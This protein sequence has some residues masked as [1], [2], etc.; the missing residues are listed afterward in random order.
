MYVSFVVIVGPSYLSV[1]DLELGDDDDDGSITVTNS[2]VNLVD[3]TTRSAL[4]PAEELAAK[5]EHVTA[6]LIE[7]AESLS[8]PLTEEVSVI[9]PH[10][11]DSTADLPFHDEPP[12]DTADAT[13]NPSCVDEM[14]ATGTDLKTGETQAEVDFP[15]QDDLWEDVE[16]WIPNYEVP[17]I[18][19]TPPSDVDPEEYPLRFDSED[20]QESEDLIGLDFEDGP[21]PAFE[22][23]ESV[24]EYADNYPEQ[25]AGGVIVELP[26]SPVNAR[27]SPFRSPITKS[28][29]LWSDDEGEDPG[30]LPRFG[31]VAHIEVFDH[32]DSPA[33]EIHE[34]TETEAQDFPIGEERSDTIVVISKD[35]TA[36]GTTQQL[37]QEPR[38]SPEVSVRE[39]AEP[40]PTELAPSTSVSLRPQSPSRTSRTH[41]IHNQASSD[42]R[43]RGEGSGQCRRSLE[44][45][46]PQYFHCCKLSKSDG[47]PK[48][49]ENWKVENPA[50]CIPKRTSLQE[51]QFVCPTDKDGENPTTRIAIDNLDADRFRTLDGLLSYNY[52]TEAMGFFST[53]SYRCWRGRAIEGIEY[54]SV[55]YATV[56]FESVGEAVRMFNELQGRR[57][58]GH[59]WHWRL[60]FVDPR[61]ES[62]GGRKIVR[63]ELV[64]DSVKQALAAELEASTRN[65]S[66]PSRSDD[67]TGAR[68]ST[69]T[70]PR[71]S[72]GGRSL[73]IGAMSNVVQDRRTV[74]QPTKSAKRV[75]SRRPYS[76]S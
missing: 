59:T 21:A 45:P 12:S 64:P 32:L 1:Q 49:W 72:V 76:R 42:N 54:S 47:R 43:A 9:A 17:A 68:S 19:I 65:S 5:L 25:P 41:R 34:V 62:H 11:D 22:H 16:S 33:V 40:T 52:L 50:A 63:A 66:N 23:N 29:M 53:T 48:S 26:P 6:T 2:I 13:V 70:R 31:E 8:E 46:R 36:S 75:P 56:D 44:A 30:P 27:D 18:F 37:T 7:E 74:E 61:D 28:G 14:T 3:L 69:R 58:R 35:L 55:G 4:P 24:F 20:E 57:F 39:V 10:S 67:T 73:L 60:E 38:S 51:W 71:L 15:A